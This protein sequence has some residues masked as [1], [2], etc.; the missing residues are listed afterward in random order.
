MWLVNGEAGGWTI[1]KSGQIGYVAAQHKT[2][3][4]SDLKQ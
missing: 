4:I 2:E 1:S 3:N